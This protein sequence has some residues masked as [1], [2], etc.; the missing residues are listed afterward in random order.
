M[1]AMAGNF[2]WSFDWPP[3]PA[4][5]TYEAAAL[6]GAAATSGWR[7]AF[8]TLGCT[9]R[10]ELEALCRTAAKMLGGGVEAKDLPHS[11]I[12]LAAVEK[13]FLIL[14]GKTFAETFQQTMA[15][16]LA[17][18]V[19]KPEIQWNIALGQQPEAPAL[20]DAAQQDLS[21]LQDQVEALFQQV[22]ILCVPTTRDAAFDAEVRYPVEQVGEAFSNYL[23][24]MLPTFAGT[25]LL[26]PTVSLPVGFLP[27][28]RPVGMQ[29]LGPPGA[30]A[31]VLEAAAYLEVLLNLPTAC[32][33]PRRGT[34][35]LGTAGPRTK[36]EAK[37][38]H[39]GEE[40]RI[41]QR[42]RTESRL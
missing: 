39:E 1:D 18:E 4:G 40:R 20:A 14:R 5:E 29:L 32:P 9:M 26:S 42:F 31:K 27:D 35:D 23:G 41:V 30:D 3:L 11:A 6:R 13:A 17:A 2:T 25:V 33:E 8:S 12:D 15:N 28:G 34:V 22:D 36:A 10:P 7:V 37:S 38:H 21:R 19:I 16:P 24:W